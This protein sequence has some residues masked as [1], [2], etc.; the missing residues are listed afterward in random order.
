MTQ[1]FTDFVLRGQQSLYQSP[2]NEIAKLLAQVKQGG[3]NGQIALRKLRSIPGGIEALQADS[4]PPAPSAPSARPQAAQPTQ[5]V[6]VQ[7]PAPPRSTNIIGQTIGRGI[8]PVASE[9]GRGTGAFGRW[10]SGTSQSVVGTPGELRDPLTGET[11]N[12]IENLQKGPQGLPTAEEIY[13]QVEET[14]DDLRS[15]P[16]AEQELYILKKQLESVGMDRP[17]PGRTVEE[18]VENARIRLQS[19]FDVSPTTG[20]TRGEQIIRGGTNPAVLAQ[21]GTLPI[22]TVFAPGEVAGGLAVGQGARLFSEATGIGDPAQFE[23]WGTLGGS[24]LGMPAKNPASVLR[25]ADELAGLTAAGRPIQGAPGLKS[26]LGLDFAG[27]ELSQIARAGQAIGRPV[28][29]GTRTGFTEFVQPSLEAAARATGREALRQAERMPGGIPGVAR[30]ADEPI[31]PPRGAGGD[32]PRTLETAQTGQP[33]QA[34][35]F[36][37]QGGATRGGIE[38]G[39]ANIV[40]EGRYSTPYREYAKIFGSDVQEVDVTL[41]NPLV[42]R[43]DAEYAKVIKD[44]GLEP[45]SMGQA[46]LSDPDNLSVA[47]NNARIAQFRN[48]VDSQ[49]YDGIVFDPP[50]TSDAGRR[51]LEDIGESQVVQFSRQADA[52]ARGVGDVPAK[53]AFDAVE[54]EKVTVYD[55]AGNP[56]EAT[57]AYRSN[58]HKRYVAVTVMEDGRKSGVIQLEDA[59]TGVQGDAS[60]AGLLYAENPTTPAYKALIDENNQAEKIKGKISRK[61][62]YSDAESDFINKWWQR[63][64]A[65]QEAGSAADVAPITPATQADVAARGVGDVPV[66]TS[67]VLRQGPN[68]QTDELPQSILRIFRESP[69]QDGATLS[70]A[71]QIE[72]RDFLR[73]KGTDFNNSPAI[74]GIIRGTFDRSYGGDAEIYVGSFKLGE[75]GSP[76]YVVWNPAKGK[77]RTHGTAPDATQIRITRKR[78]KNF[79][80]ENVMGRPHA[81]ADETIE[82]FG[83]DIPQAGLRPS[84]PALTSP[85]TPATQTDVAARG[86][87]NREAIL[88]ARQL[89]NATVNTQLHKPAAQRII[90]AAGTDD[91]QGIADFYSRELGLEKMTVVRRGGLNNAG[92]ALVAENGQAALIIAPDSFFRNNAEKIMWL[93]H[94]IQHVIDAKSGFTPS[95]QSSIRGSDEAGNIVIQPGH[96]QNIEHFETDFPIRALAGDIDDPAFKQAPTTSAPVTRQQGAVS[97]AAEEVAQPQLIDDAKLPPEPPPA[98]P[99]ATGGKPRDWSKVPDTGR[100]GVLLEVPPT[101]I[102]ENLLDLRPIQVREL[103]VVDRSLNAARATLGKLTNKEVVLKNKIVNAAFAEVRRVQSRITSQANL[104]SSAITKHAKAFVTDKQGRIPSLAGI[105][106]SL[107]GAP[108]IQDVAARRPRYLAALTEEQKNALEQIRLE[109]DDY[110]IAREEVGVEISGRSDLVAGAN[111]TESG[112]YIPRGGN[113]LSPDL[114]RSTRQI[115][116]RIGAEQKAAYDSMAQAIDDGAT[117]FPLGD[118]IKTFGQTLGERL[119]NQH[120]ANFLRRLEVETG[121]P[122]GRAGGKPLPG[123][124]S[125]PAGSAVP[126]LRELRGTTFPPE[127]TNAVNEILATQGELVGRGSEVL[128]WLNAYNNFYR[129]A[130]STA[131]NSAIMIQGLLG[132][133]SDPEASARALLLNME[134]W[135]TGEARAIFGKFVKETDQYANDTLGIPNFSQTAAQKGL[136][137][138]GGETELTQSL[139]TRLPGARRASNAF[140]FYGDALRLRWLADEVVI[141]MKRQGKTARQIVDDGTLE[142]SAKAINAATGMSEGNRF[143]DLSSL[144]LFAPRFLQSRLVTV[145]RGIRGLDVDA[146]LDILPSSLRRRVPLSPAPLNRAARLQDRIARKALIRLIGW[147]AAIT[148]GANAALGQETDFRLF[149][150][151]RPNPN[152]MRIRFGERDYSVYG[153][154]D[155]IGKL[156]IGTAQ[157]LSKGQLDTILESGRGLGSGLVV[158]AWDFFSRRDFEGRKTRDTPEQ[159]AAHVTRSHLPFQ[160]EELPAATGKI[161]QG[162]REGDIGQIAT[163]AAQI[164]LEGHGAKSSPLSRGDQLD[165]LAKSQLGKSYS[166]INLLERFQLESD[167]EIAPLLAEIDADLAAR[168]RVSAEYRVERANAENALKDFQQQDLDEFILQWRF[169]PWR[170]SGN[171]IYAKIGDREIT[172]RGLLNDL[173]EYISVTKGNIYANLNGWRKAK[174]LDNYV[175]E[176]PTNEFDKMLNDWYDL[177]DE[178]TMSTKIG[179]SEYEGRLIFDTWIP[180][181]EKFISELTPELQ[182]QL[183]EWRDRKEDIPGLQALLDL[184]GPIGKKADGSLEWHSHSALLQEIGKILQEIGITNDYMNNL[185]RAQ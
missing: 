119:A 75:S 31:V 41:Q 60:S 64:D 150:N 50:V 169:L 80:I 109:L 34:R 38:E 166:E 16:K 113:P 71:E 42:I 14:G 180:A 52:A 82:I 140:G 55:S 30:F 142:N 108:T 132:S 118:T 107:P 171:R 94:E 157:G 76:Q 8:G 134:I 66:D 51:M 143:T 161:I 165:I 89:D 133:A 5:A 123:E 37:G 23:K 141:E 178:H 73:E 149:V 43:T 87:V 86:G 39:G 115:G 106:P 101:E 155:S 59:V 179:E 24:F 145:A 102:G 168:G 53:S 124:I 112:F 21:I 163:G 65:A 44:A 54:G 57:V 68:V 175:G 28:I 47:A 10:V 131:D 162:T 177:L 156:I 126:T 13:K 160:A 172:V 116:G 18:Q 98:R 67:T 46:R 12:T 99:I 11:F 78:I 69:G 129:G 184:R 58:T 144:V 93:R 17:I 1:S 77:F 79:G 120:A 6:D 122:L 146:P 114:P 104:K 182:Q 173:A 96:F 85:T 100:Q 128:K 127:I 139:V 2:Q 105:D 62:G 151:G 91:L 35:L 9:V 88:N 167:P 26:T 32:V 135:R 153:T 130:R 63:Q 40:G 136:I 95:V 61:E 158:Q 110:R 148:V 176:E 111:P 7:P 81:S 183:A 72:L 159:F 121:I 147:G 45:T 84:T 90:E 97:Q 117:Y 49:G 170:Q 103:G 137:I 83:E 48:Y 56:R 15:L 70:R 152:F 92:E 29:S 164:A 36:R 138:N 181:S 174:G 74:G 125:I 3:S 25:Q 27:D 33:F 154:W 20:Q 19:S 4:A 185:K 22:T